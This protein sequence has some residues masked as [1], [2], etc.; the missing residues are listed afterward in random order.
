MIY[1]NVI[2]S[3]HG[4]EKGK[5]TMRDMYNMTKV[6]KFSSKYYMLKCISSLLSFAKLFIA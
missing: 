2:I 6:S 4:I 1:S 3:V 5:Q